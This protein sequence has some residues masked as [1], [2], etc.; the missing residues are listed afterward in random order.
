[1]QTFKRA[2]HC[3]GGDGPD[4]GVEERRSTTQEACVMDRC[5]FCGDRAAMEGR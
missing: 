1:M 5:T 2:P 3:S 4:M